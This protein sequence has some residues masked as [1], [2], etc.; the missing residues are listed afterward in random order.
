MAKHTDLR[1]LIA[2]VDTLPVADRLIIAGRLIAQGDPSVTD[3]AMKLAENV[4]E[5][6]KAIKVLGRRG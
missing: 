5:D 3:F 1:D 6:W 2:D 4:V